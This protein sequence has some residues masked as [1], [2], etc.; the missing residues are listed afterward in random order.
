MIKGWTK[1]SNIRIYDYLPSVDDLPIAAIIATD[2]SK[3]G[4]MS[5]PSYDLYD[6]MARITKHNIIASG[7]V[8]G[9]ADIEK[10]RE[11]K[12]IWCDHR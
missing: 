9:K 1:G 12:L 11:T 3:D 4:M 2:I 5:G 8:S 6:R 10:L 7:G